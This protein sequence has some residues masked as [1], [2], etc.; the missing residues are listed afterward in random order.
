MLSALKKIYNF[1]KQA[2]EFLLTIIEGTATLL[3]TVAEAVT[4]P[5]LLAGVVPGVIGACII[6]VGAIAVAKLVI[7]RG[8]K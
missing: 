2:F 3:E 7:G 4:L 6:A 8:N 1:V 5:P